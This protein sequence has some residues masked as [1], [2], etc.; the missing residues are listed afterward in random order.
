LPLELVQSLFQEMKRSF[1]PE[2]YQVTD[3][4][5][6]INKNFVF[7]GLISSL[8]RKHQVATSLRSFSMLLLAVDASLIANDMNDL[9]SSTNDSKLDTW[10]IWGRSSV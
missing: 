6:Y 3:E 10:G 9:E 4:C 2:D 8:F 7:S 5:L 1:P